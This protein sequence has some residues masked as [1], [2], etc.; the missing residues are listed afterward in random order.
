MTGSSA[1]FYLSVIP[2][3]VINGGLILGYLIFLL[4]GSFKK[5]EIDSQVKAE[6][7]LM[8]VSLQNYWFTITS[9]FVKL[10]IKLK[11]SA[12]MITLTGLALSIISAFFY[13]HKS[14]G[15]AGWIMIAGAVFD[16][17]DGRV[18]RMTNTVSKKGA[19]LDS[20]V[21]RYSDGIILSGLAVAFRDHWMLYPVLLCL[22]GFFCVSYAKAKAEADGTK[23]NVGMFQRP[24]RIFAL[25]LSS[26]FSPIVSYY[27][28]ISYPVLIYISVTLLG[29]G[30]ILTSV[31]R[32][33]YAFNRL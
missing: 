5:P 22:V 15:L 16:L 25:G 3:I 17:F 7:K 12:N 10:L 2:L 9:P 23:C 19:Y 18:A 4:A 8:W 13:S 6:S 29:A 33:K 30:T 31:Y 24:E 28:D 26:I 20:T 14:W 27:F 21:D 11:I 32:V 1:S